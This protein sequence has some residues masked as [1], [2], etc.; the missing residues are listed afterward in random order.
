[1]PKSTTLNDLEGLLCSCTPFQNICFETERNTTQIIHLYLLAC[2]TD[3]TYLQG[4]TVTT[5]TGTDYVATSTRCMIRT[6]VAVATITVV[7]TTTT[8][9]TARAMTA[10]ATVLDKLSIPHIQL[11]IGCQ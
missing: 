8:R 5:T 4:T 6:L 3:G 10:T 2:N 9:A 11:P 7:T 1:V